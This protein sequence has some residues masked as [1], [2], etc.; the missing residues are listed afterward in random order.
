MINGLPMPKISSDD[1]IGLVSAVDTVLSLGRRAPSANMAKA[2]EE[3]NRLVSKA[4]GLSQFE[5]DVIDRSFAKQAGQK[6]N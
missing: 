1:R 5:L 4:Y 2:Q 6:A 3:V